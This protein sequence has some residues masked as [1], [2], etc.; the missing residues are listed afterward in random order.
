LED[1]E[2]AAYNK[3]AQFVNFQVNL[4]N[5]GRNM[6]QLETDE[7]QFLADIADTNRAAANILQYAYGFIYDDC[8]GTEGGNKSTMAALPGNNSANAIYIEAYPSPAGTWISFEYLLPLNETEAYISI[9][10]ANGRIIEKV[11]LNTNCGQKVIDVRKLNNGIWF[12][13][14]H[15][16]GQSK[17]G[18]FIVQH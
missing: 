10:D 16:A 14:L 12:Y 6:L 4:V 3:Y 9:C 7:I 8:P 1:D 15:A 17:S 13:S 5:D 18:K 2:L 11:Q